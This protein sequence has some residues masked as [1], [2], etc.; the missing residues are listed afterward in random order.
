[1]RLCGACCKRRKT[2]LPEQIVAPEGD[3]EGSHT[4]WSMDI[5]RRFSVDRTRYV[6]QTHSHCAVSTIMLTEIIEGTIDYIL[7]A[8]PPK[9]RQT[10]E[11]QKFG[12]GTIQMAG[13]AWM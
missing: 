10:R 4:R 2:H 9:I 3:V 1:M 7:V 5:M 12:L 11:G 8:N 6:L 13:R